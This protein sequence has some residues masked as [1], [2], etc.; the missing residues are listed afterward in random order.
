MPSNIIILHAQLLLIFYAVSS[1]LTDVSNRNP[2]ITQHSELLRQ[3]NKVLRQDNKVLT[4]DN[5]VV[6]QHVK[7]KWLSF[8]RLGELLEQSLDILLLEFPDLAERGLAL[9]VLLEHGEQQFHAEVGIGERPLL[10]VQQIVDI[11]HQHE[12]VELSQG[13]E[14]VEQAQVGREV[15]VAVLV[16]KG[17]VQVEVVDHQQVYLLQAA[18]VLPVEFAHLPH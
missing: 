5:K 6:M 11:V 18:Q 2:L 7:S 3:D 10:R 1:Y 15:L 13:F 9:R 17:E 14:L 4:Q 12:C 8:G 16:D